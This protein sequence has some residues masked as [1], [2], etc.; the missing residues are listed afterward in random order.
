MQPFNTYCFL[1]SSGV[2][3][4]TIANHLQGETILKTAE[5]S[6]QTN[7]GRHTTSH[8]AL[9]ILPNQSIII[10]TP[11]MR[12]IGMT[13]QQLGI[14]STFDQIAVLSEQCKFNNCTHTNEVGCMILKAVDGGEVPLE[15]YENFLKLKREQAH[16]ST[17]VR[18]RRKKDREQGKLYKNIQKERR[19][20]KF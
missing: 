1:G 15:A 17:T 14:E 8:R 2:G 7:K 5:I 9:F 20:K 6:H 19:K 13:D 11:G 4:S 10:D 12:E 18:E 3:K 16:F